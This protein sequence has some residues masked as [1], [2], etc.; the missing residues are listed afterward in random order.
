VTAYLVSGEVIIYVTN[1]RETPGFRLDGPLIDTLAPTSA[2][3]CSYAYTIKLSTNQ[4]TEIDNSQT[5][6][7]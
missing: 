7:N 1:N 4:I 3:H 5:N 6:Y 2:L